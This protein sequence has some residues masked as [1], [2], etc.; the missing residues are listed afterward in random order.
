MLKQ[1]HAACDGW[2]LLWLRTVAIR[3]SD[4]PNMPNMLAADTFTSKDIRVICMACFQRTQAQ[5]KWNL[6]LYY[7]I[8][9]H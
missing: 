9:M 3:M 7:C 4:A 8:T 5:S 2:S 1:Q 6:V